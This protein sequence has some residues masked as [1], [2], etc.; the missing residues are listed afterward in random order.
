VHFALKN[1][2][3]AGIN[4]HVTVLPGAAV[5]ASAMKLTHESGSPLLSFGE[6]FLT[7]SDSIG[8]SAFTT[9]HQAL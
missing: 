5:G 3:K 6:K 8:A 4:R 1:A 9:A 7:M 2:S